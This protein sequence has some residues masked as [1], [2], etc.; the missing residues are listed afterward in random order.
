MLGSWANI[1]RSDDKQVTFL[2][3]RS[4]GTSAGVRLS[5]SKRRTIMSVLERLVERLGDLWEMQVISLL[6]Y[7][8]STPTPRKSTHKSKNVVSVLRS[9]E[10][11]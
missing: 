10:K 5:R 11:L 8:Y 4:A 1:G 9:S 6:V 7:E 2:A 3:I